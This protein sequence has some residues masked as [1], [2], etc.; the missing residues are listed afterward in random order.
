VDVLDRAALG[1]DPAAAE[2]QVEVLDVEGQEFPGAGGGLVE[3]PPQDPFAQAVPVAGEQLVQAGAGD[4][5]IAAAGGLA[6]FQ[7]AGGVGGEDLLPPGP[8]GEGGERGQVPVPGGGRRVV[9]SVHH[10]GVVLGKERGGVA[11]AG[12]GDEAGESAGVAGAGGLGLDRVEVAVDGGR[13]DLAAG[14]GVGGRGRE[15]D[16]RHE[17]PP[18]LM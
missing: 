4:G 10:R 14:G 7:A 12:A 1:G 17:G 5:P 9:P 6:A 11:A 2:L 8:G 13:Y 18:A 15:R 16:D 3:H